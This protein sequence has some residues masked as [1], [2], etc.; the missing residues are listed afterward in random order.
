[1][2]NHTSTH[3][4]RLGRTT[5]L[6]AALTLGSSYAQAAILYWDGADTTA[7]ADGGTGT[8]N[9]VATNW[10]SAATA[11][12]NTPWSNATP[13]EAIFGGVAG[14]VT[15][16]GALTV[17]KITFNVAGYTLSGGTSLT[18][19]GTTPSITTTTG[20]STTISSVIAG[21]AA[22][23]K[24]GA[25]NLI[26]N[27]GNTYTGA[28]TVNAGNLIAASASALGTTAGATTVANG[29][30]LQI[31]GNPTIAEAI[32]I[33]G[34]GPGGNGSL[35]G[36][37]GGGTLSGVVTLGSDS[38]IFRTGGATG[39][40]QITGGITGANRNLTVNTGETG[41]NSIV[42]S[43]I[44]TGTGTFTKGLAGNVTF[45]GGAANT[46]SG[47]TTINSGTI[48]MN[49]TSGIT[50]IAGNVL[51][52]GGGTL[53]SAS[54]SNQIADT[55]TVTLGDTSTTGTYNF[56]AI[57]LVETIATLSLV[58]GSV[59]GSGFAGVSLTVN[60]TL[61]VREGSVSTILAGGAGL[62]KTTTGTVTLSGSEANTFTGA[63]NV[64]AGTLALNKTAGINALASTTLNIT[65]AASILSLSASD[66]IANGATLTLATSGTFAMGASNETLA[67][68]TLTDG[69]VTGSGTLTATSALNVRNGS[70]SAI[71]AGA[72]GL[73]KTTAGTVTLS[74]GGANTFTGAVSV[75]AG[76]LLLNKTA[77]INAIG[78][79]GTITVNTGATLQIGANEQIIDAK[80]ITLNGSAALNLGAFEETIG[81]LTMNNT[82]TMSGGT[83][84]A[85]SYAYNVTTTNDTIST[86]L[87][88]SGTFTKS[89]TNNLTLSGNSSSYTGNV[90][91]NDGEMNLIS[92][93]AV[94]STG[95]VNVGGF[96]VLTMQGNITVPGKALVL[97]GYGDL[98]N[99]GLDPAYGRGTFIN[100]SDNNT[101]TGAVTLAA[102]STVAS[103]N[104]KLTITGDISGAGRVLWTVITQDVGETNTV[105]FAG[106]L[107]VGFLRHYTGAGT[108]LISGTTA[109][110]ISGG[111]EVGSITTGGVNGTGG[112]MLLS[113]TAGVDALSGTGITVN[114]SATLQLGNNNQ[115]A[116]A[117][118]LTITKGSFN[119]GGY[120]E[121]L[122]ALV[123][124][125][126]TISNGTIIASNYDAQKGLI[127]ANLG[128]ST[129]GTFTKNTANTVTLSGDN[130][131]YN[132]AMT[133]A[134]GILIAA[135]N[136][137]LGATTSATTVNNGTTL[138]LQGGITIAGEPVTLAGTGTA[139]QGA[140]VNGSGNNALNGPITLSGATTIGSTAGK[141]TLGGAIGGVQ[142]LTTDGAGDIEISGGIN[143]G[144]AT[145]TKNGAGT[146]TLSGASAYT[147]A[148]TVNTG[149]LN[150]RNNTALGTVA[151]GV[152]VG[153]GAEL[154]LQGGITVGAE[155]LTLNGTS[156]F[157]NVAGNNTWGGALTTATSTITSDAGTMTLSGSIA[158]SGATT[159]SG[160]GDINASGI[161]GGS[162]AIT[163]TGAGTTRF[164]GNNTSTGNL[165]V[166]AGTLL[167]NGTNAM[168][169]GTVTVAAA[170]TLGGTGS[171]T[172]TGTTS[173]S[174]A[175]QGGIGATGQALTITNSNITMATGSVIQLA[176]G[177]GFT[178]S[179]IAKSGGTFAF[180]A[181]QMFNFIDLGATTGTYS[182]L[183]TGVANPGAGI[184][185]WTI[186]NAG[187]TGTFSWAGN[188][189]SLN[190]TSVPE[191]STYGLIGAGLLAVAS[192]VRRRKNQ[193]A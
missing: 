169:A 85:T 83:I 125:D 38:T 10:D 107:N 156:T 35:V 148:T 130:S 109:N 188:N 49:K 43:A 31:Q 189:I 96:G 75:D 4:G 159:F 68:L 78:G 60:T 122:A 184:S 28:T 140:L 139:G 101:W 1:M 118:P 111:V 124:T 97:N 25:G 133:V 123:L 3:I 77:G 48:S 165:A 152:T 21:A 126:G 73:T 137:A 193:V 131:A 26:L 87:K 58:N 120:S 19:G 142:N 104:G 65:G 171:Y 41:G 151:G 45:S 79:A 88:G 18:L 177:A 175:L 51:V 63:V 181:N 149:I 46:Y 37:A 92:N 76:T 147:G 176:L 145:L 185:G 172:S 174:G 39:L 103:E 153:T 50:S 167:L 93:N 17:N 86:N 91:V 16:S 34:N 74:G 5:L 30:S 190:L 24:E 187:Y 132:R 106:A 8:W 170:G 110:V 182:N 192:M 150:I 180:S 108:T 89:S 57:N 186:S 36:A 138:Q 54:T 32:T 127:S 29:A 100:Y 9:N 183:I 155:A 160:A 112:T 95:T 7:D 119:L 15:L 144:T 105:E 44:T 70:I 56:N 121:T 191:T 2:R 81:A 178:K 53:L 98:I 47:L 59:T 67:T 134:G 157:R 117:T 136:T 64:N 114:N 82:S 141:L 90:A 13:D 135:S 55:S 179:T 72:A 113:K 164:T 69:S 23:S 52:I 168:G 154:Q 33:N 128:N 161:I 102:D 158:R 80:A 66:Q 22:W 129:A 115:I 12:A 14:T 20:A 84:N 11:G 162:T 6:A 143:T 94:G 62:T 99:N 146:L 27:G 71:L 166:N 173:V 40:F 61:D 116:D 163:K 42:I